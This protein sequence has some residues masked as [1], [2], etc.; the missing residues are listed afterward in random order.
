MKETRREAG[1]FVSSEY[2]V[3]SVIAEFDVGRGLFFQNG[4]HLKCLL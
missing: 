3:G 2:R 4:I 1:F